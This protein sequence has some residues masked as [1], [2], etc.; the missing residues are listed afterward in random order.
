[1]DQSQLEQVIRSQ[2]KRQG[3]ITFETF[4]KMARY[5]PEDGYYM[6]DDLRTC[7]DGDFLH[8]FPPA[9]Y[10]W[11]VAGRA[12]GSNEKGDGWADFAVIEIGGGKGYLDESI[13]T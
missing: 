5:H 7:P 2:I 1:M 10:I 9:P 12:T 8:R 4:M 6:T 11:L 13:L 3:P